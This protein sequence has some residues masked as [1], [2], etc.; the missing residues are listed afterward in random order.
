MTDTY[1]DKTREKLIFE[2]LQRKSM[3]EITVHKVKFSLDELAEALHIKGKISS[4]YVSTYKEGSIEI[5]LEG[6]NK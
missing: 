5:T 1:S 3:E 4:A 6:E 2:A